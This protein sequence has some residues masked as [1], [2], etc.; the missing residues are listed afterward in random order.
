[1]VLPE[2]CDFP[3]IRSRHR[4]GL[5]SLD[6]GSRPAGCYPAT[7]CCPFSPGRTRQPDKE[8]ISAIIIRE[9]ITISIH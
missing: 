9:M 8:D 3:A 2:N 6:P 1:V 7:H 5:A 4:P